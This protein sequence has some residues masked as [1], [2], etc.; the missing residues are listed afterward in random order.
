MLQTRVAQANS[1][2]LYPAVVVGTAVIQDVT[3]L[4]QFGFCNRPTIESKD[5]G[6]SAHKQ[7]PLTGWTWAADASSDC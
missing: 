7:I 4:L 1:A 6:D 3:H 2:A 5:S